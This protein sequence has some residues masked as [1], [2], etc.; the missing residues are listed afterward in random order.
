M[1]ST[2]TQRRR[3]AFA[4][5]AMALAVAMCLTLW[6]SR[7]AKAA[8]PNPIRAGLIFNTAKTQNTNVFSTSLAPTTSSF[9]D[10]AAFRVTICLVSTNSVVNVQISDGQNTVTPDLNSGTALTA[11]VLYTFSFAVPEGYTLNFQ[12]ETSTTIGLLLVEEVTGDAL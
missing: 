4:F 6:P 10:S 2:D 1:N 12:V 9:R 8:P 7:N 11:G 3:A 5:V